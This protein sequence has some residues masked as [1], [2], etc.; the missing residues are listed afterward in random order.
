MTAAAD[1]TGRWRAEWLAALDALEA[2]VSS[3]EQMILDDHR[4]RDHPITGHWAPPA[5]IGSLPLDLVP[6]ADEILA[7][8]MAAAKAIVIAIAVN[9]RQATAVARIE[10]GSR[11]APRPAFVDQ[12]L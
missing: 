9:R 5:G 8:Q 2:D 10:V 3:V 6:R 11:G 7:R 12:A 4:F 1:P